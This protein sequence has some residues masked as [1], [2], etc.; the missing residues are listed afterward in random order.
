MQQPMG[1]VLARLSGVD[2]SSDDPAEGIPTAP[3]A[4]Q[5]SSPAIT[6]R[7]DHAPAALPSIADPLSTSRQEDV[8]VAKPLVPEQP[9]LGP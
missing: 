4:L 3:Q 9:K 2:T 8:I 6:P 7:R 5:P 1:K